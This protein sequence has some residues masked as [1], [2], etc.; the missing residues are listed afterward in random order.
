M[1][2]DA[3]AALLLPQRRSP[4]GERGL[5]FA[6]RIDILYIR[7]SLPTRGAWI[8]MRQE[9]GWSTYKRR[10]PHGERGLK[11]GECVSVLLTVESL[12]TR[13]AWIEILWYLS[14]AP[15]VPSLPTRGAWI[16]IFSSGNL[17]S[18][19]TRRS[20]HGERGLKFRSDKPQ[21]KP[22]RSLPTRG[23]WIEI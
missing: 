20:P 18:T 19:L 4:H 16:E 22:F 17:S 11:S 15:P 5:K 23:A 2:S 12:P 14:N 1:K 6:C 9:R 10:S 3:W 21:A 13:G 8:E 7:P